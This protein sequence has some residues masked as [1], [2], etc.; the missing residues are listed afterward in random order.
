MKVL[1]FDPSAGA[2]GDMIMA[3]LLDLGADLPAVRQ[4]VESVGC[5]LE[6]SRQK[7]RSIMASRAAV[8]SGRRFHSLDE[9]RSI[10]SSSCLRGKALE[11]ALRALDILA[12]AEG[13]VHGS[14]PEQAHF[15]E[16]GALDALADIAGSSAARASLEAERVLCL[17][18]SLG[19]GFIQSAHGL[20]PVPV[21][22]KGTRLAELHPCRGGH[23]YG[24]HGGFINP[25]A[26]EQRVC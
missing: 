8:T 4:A 20:L 15:H 26:R 2:S 5:R 13:R 10:L 3:S 24:Q 23:Q 19:G 6:V 17:P 9:A 11:D 22:Q 12:E 21:A 16:V 1:L 14:S 25:A 18:L 7:K